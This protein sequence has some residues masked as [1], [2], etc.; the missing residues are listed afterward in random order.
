MSFTAVE[1]T[2]PRQLNQSGGNLSITA[3]VSPNWSFDL[4]SGS[5]VVKGRA[6]LGINQN[7]G[8][9]FSK[10]I[11][12]NTTDTISLVGDT[13][14]KT[15]AFGGNQQTFYC[16]LDGTFTIT[17]TKTFVL[18]QVYKSGNSITANGGY[19][20]TLTNTEDIYATL[21]ITKIA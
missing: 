3:P 16:H 6:Q 4:P 1:S 18:N 8:V 19:T 9:M 10:L 17:A 13:I 7:G 15:G 2:Q 12:L 11:L 21:V 20:S 14:K 5:Y